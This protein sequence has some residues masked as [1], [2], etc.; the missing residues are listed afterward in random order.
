[1]C[2]SDLDAPNLFRLGAF[3]IG[4]GGGLF[5]VGT[6]TMAMDLQIGDSAGM[7]LGAWGAV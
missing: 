2:S 7:A 4:A 5:S 3:L 1:M 6:L